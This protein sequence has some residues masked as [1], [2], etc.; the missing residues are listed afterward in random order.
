MLK[1][2]IYLDLPKNKEEQIEEIEEKEEESE[3]EKEAYDHEKETLKKKKQAKY[4]NNFLYFDDIFL[5]FINLLD[6]LKKR[7]K[8]SL[9][10]CSQRSKNE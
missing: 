6:L 10:Q 8:I 7:K 1:S 2:I 3:E 5:N 4:L 9:K